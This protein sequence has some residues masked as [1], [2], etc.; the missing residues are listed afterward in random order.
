MSNK[1]EYDVFIK[2]Y[3][4][5]Q[6]MVNIQTLEASRDGVTSFDCCFYWNKNNYY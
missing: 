6:I 4:Y 5:H 3:E 1:Q 2:I